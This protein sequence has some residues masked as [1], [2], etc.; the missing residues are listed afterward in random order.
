MY[1]YSYYAADGTPLYI[2]K[3]AQ[4]L[5]R[6]QQHWQTDSW[7]GEVASIT[8][9][10]PYPEEDVLFYEK[11]H[12]TEEQ[13]LYNVNGLRFSEANKWVKDP[14][15][16]RN[17]ETVADFQDYYRVQPDTLQRATYYFRLVD[18]EVLRILQFYRNSDVS[19]IVREALEIG[20][21]ELAK[22]LDHE[23]IYAEAL[24]RMAHSE[25]WRRNRQR[26]KRR[27]FKRIN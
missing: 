20:V 15:E 25:G 2:G 21:Q 4:V 14:Y 12:I 19:G 6:F 24:E 23:D 16:V 26:H 7:M 18:L 11:K 13:P 8:V 3:A 17:F 9:R 10:G 27:N 1:I 22:R 5:L